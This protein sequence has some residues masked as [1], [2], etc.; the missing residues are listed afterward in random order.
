MS[1][2]FRFSVFVLAWIVSLCA[3]LSQAGNMPSLLAGVNRTLEAQKSGNTPNPPPSRSI[4]VSYYYDE[5]QT[6]SGMSEDEIREFFVS[7]ATPS[8]EKM[9]WYRWGKGEFERLRLGT[10]PAF[11]TE[12]T[13]FG[14][15][16]AGKGLY[17]AES[18]ASSAEFGEYHGDP[19]IVAVCAP[20]GTLLLDLKNPEVLSK[21][22]EKSLFP[23]DVFK[24]NP[25]VMVKFVKD[26]WV[27]KSPAGVKIKEYNGK[28]IPTEMLFEYETRIR[29]KQV[30]DLHHER[31][32]STLD[33]RIFRPGYE[34]VIPNPK[35]ACE[36][37]EISNS[38]KWAKDKITEYFWRYDGTCGGYVVQDRNIALVED[39][40]NFD[41]CK[42]I[43]ATTVSAD[44][45][46]CVKEDPRIIVFDGSEGKERVV[47]NVGQTLAPGATGRGSE[48]DIKKDFES[49]F[50]R[51]WGS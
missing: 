20:R 35:T 36:P 26:Y 23:E 48:K 2:N 44:G 51:S 5:V 25:P 12:T 33:R 8:S 29:N 30:R 15:K 21:M 19:E 18:P 49:W 17:V 43:Y 13:N 11:E 47:P 41:H 1:K 46:E 7:L 24:T 4:P 14:L 40:A 9:I 34:E 42:R 31:I 22:K 27:L 45:T 37:S 38:E 39:R 32:K 3:S 10:V 16:R 50:Y 6:E 28:Y